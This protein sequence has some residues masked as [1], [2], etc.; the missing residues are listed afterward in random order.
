MKCII[1]R[2]EILRAATAVA[3]VSP[4]NAMLNHLKGLAVE[5]TAGGV[6]LHA[7]N[8]TS[9]VRVNVRGNTTDGGRSVVVPAARFLKVIKQMSGDVVTLEVDSQSRLA[10][11]STDGSRFKLLTDQESSPP[12]ELELVECSGSVSV[13]AADI[14]RIVSATVFAAEDVGGRFIFDGVKLEVD[15]EQTLTAVATNGRIV[16]WTDA[17]IIELPSA[18][19][20]VATTVVPTSSV[21]AI[22]SA[23][24]DDDSPVEITFGSNAIRVTHASATL[25]CLLLDGRFPDWRSATPD[26]YAAEMT[27]PA[28]ELSRVL[29]GAM[30]MVDD[31]SS[32][33]FQMAAEGLTVY[34]SGAESGDSHGFVSGLNPRDDCRCKL[35]PKQ[36]SVFLKNVGKEAGVKFHAVGESG[37]V[38]LATTDGLHYLQAAMRN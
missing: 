7:A 4:K 6:T 12:P 22:G 37:P 8:L 9:T 13:T 2:N 36:M 23:I 29:S 11:S 20:N 35:N 16:T 1:E 5:F 21:N 28:N 32:A 25:T 3:K 24:P 17:P 31:D 27:L 15:A 33:E 26:S 14:R 19:I 34:G 38:Y 10:V 30:V 18:G